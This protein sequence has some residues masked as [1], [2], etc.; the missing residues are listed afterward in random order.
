MQ[1]TVHSIMYTC[2]MNLCTYC[3]DLQPLEYLRC[4]HQEEEDQHLEEEDQH[5]EDE[6]QHLEDEDQQEEGEDEQDEV[7]DP[8]PGDNAYISQHTQPIPVVR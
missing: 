3:E 6:D 8:D 4:H 5:L 1:F 7:L 2:L